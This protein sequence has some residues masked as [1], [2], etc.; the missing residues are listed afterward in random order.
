MR[1]TESSHSGVIIFSF[2]FAVLLASCSPIKNI[3]PAEYIYFRNGAD[4]IFSKQ[5]ETLIQPNDLLSIQVY[6][7]TPNQEQAAIFNMP[8]PSTTNNTT[9]AA[10]G[11]APGYQVDAAGNIEMP[12][13]GIVRAAGLTISELQNVLVQ[14][15]A[16]NV[17]YPAV[18]VS[19]LEFNINVLGEV[20]APGLHKFTTDKVTI[21]DAIAASGDLTDYGKRDSITVIR[22]E[23]G[24][25]VYHYIDLR[26]KD[27]FESPVYIMEPNDVV[28]V[29]PNRYKLRNLSINPDKQRNTSTLLAILFAAVSIASLVVA[30]SYHN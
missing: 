20:H 6:S 17:K 23:K 5:K 13:I 15:L 1:Q 11:T 19:F 26:T 27:I 12:V 21:L 14:K 29:P 16:N 18:L 7:K 25:K 22:E 3:K 8:T 4:T 2:L 10:P 30:I 24:R 9:G 28:Y